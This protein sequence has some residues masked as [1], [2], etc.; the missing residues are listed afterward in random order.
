MGPNAIFGLQFLLSLIVFALIARWYVTPWLAEKTLEQALPLLILP[1]AFRHIG[2]SFL[3]PGVVAEPLPA[4]F[5]NPAA[6]A[7]SSVSNHN[8]AHTSVP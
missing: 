6:S 8:G 2:L 1:H 4:T 3:V 7:L 5:A